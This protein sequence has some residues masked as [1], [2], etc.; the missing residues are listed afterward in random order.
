MNNTSAPTLAQAR[1]QIAKFCDQQLFLGAYLFAASSPY[2]AAHFPGLWEF[3]ARRLREGGAAELAS[4]VRA[5]LWEAGSLRGQT[6]LDEA[7]AACDAADF[8]RA[9]EVLDAVFGRNVVDADVNLVYGLAL[10]DSDPAEALSQLGRAGM[11]TLKVALTVID[12]LRRANRLSEAIETIAEAEGRFPGDPRIAARR[13]RVLERRNDWAGAVREW[14]NLVDESSIF[15]TQGLSKISALSRRLENHA[16]ADDALAELFLVMNQRTASSDLPSQVEA[17]LLAG[18]T[19]AVHSLLDRMTASGVRTRVLPADWALVA[20]TLLDDGRIGLAGWMQAQGLPIGPGV[21]SVVQAAPLSGADRQRMRGSVGAATA[22]RV[23]SPDALL[24]S[25]TS[26]S[27]RTD[28]TGAL[29][30]DRIL[31]VNATLAAGGA[32]RQFV[33]LV[34]ALLQQG[35]PRSRIHVALFSVMDERGHSHFLPA[36]R[37]TG[38]AVHILPD[39]P[40]PADRIPRAD[41]VAALPLQIRSD[42]LRLLPLVRQ[43]RPGVVHGWQDRSSVACGLAGLLLDTPRVVL[44]A[45][46]MRPELRGERRLKAM[47]GL[48]SHLCQTPGVVLTVN[49]DA[50]ARDYERWLGLAEGTAKTLHNGID[51]AA[52][53]RLSPPV[54]RTAKGAPVEVL[55]VFRLAANKRPLIWLQTVAELRRRVP[56]PIRPRLVGSGPFRDQVERESAALGLGDLILQDRLDSPAEIYGSARMLLLMSRV[57]G[58]PNVVIEAQ[59]CG[60]AVAACDVGGVNEALMQVGPGAGLLLPVEIDPA[61][62]AEKIAAWLPAALEAAPDHRRRHV[63]RTF[64]TAALARRALAL[65]GPAGAW[66]GGDADD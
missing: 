40:G 38:V 60:L 35:V 13:A 15:R 18:Q 63:E 34:N 6:A 43:L 56:F 14:R 54:R 20:Q 5:A 52:F 23:V 51:F 41:I 62:A 17:L 64:G 9:V 39:S 57:E 36:L 26:P 44:C 49:S 59:A 37:Q 16:D 22:D 7:Q 30:D 45:R 10:V 42:L 4:R 21:A 11:P 33:T 48:I 32:E 46:N 50:G 1:V 29:A 61:E 27:G 2:D 25:L 55:G 53:A 12:A 24:A 19:E 66:F 47:R 3:L 31:L 58:T 28:D 65:Y 8:S